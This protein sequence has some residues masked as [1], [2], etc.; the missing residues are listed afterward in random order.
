[1]WVG[2]GTLIIFVQHSLIHSHN[3]FCV[4]LGSVSV[5]RCALFVLG[6]SN[7]QLVNCFWKIRVALKRARFGV[8]CAG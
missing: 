7:M 1:M 3:F 2:V 4:L 5:G 8:T 6:L